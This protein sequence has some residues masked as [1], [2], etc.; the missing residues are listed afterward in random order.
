MLIRNPDLIVSAYPWPPL[1]HPKA[2]S[3]LLAF[4]AADDRLQDQRHVAYLLATIRHE[5]AFTYEPIEEIGKGAGKTYGWPDP[6]TGHAYYGRG[7]VQIT[8]RDNYERIGN[9]IGADLVHHPELALDP[10]TAYEIAA[11]GMMLGLFTGRKLAD[12]IDGPYCDYVNSRRIINAFVQ[13]EADLIA[14]YAEKFENI[15]QTK[16]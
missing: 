10:A 14:G 13:A 2:F 12:Y 5:T 7:Y 4:I 15:F 1:S 16:G 8:W 9:A 6:E 11:R 3:Q